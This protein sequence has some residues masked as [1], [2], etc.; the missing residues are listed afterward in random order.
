MNA[1]SPGLDETHDARRRSW[2]EGA[3]G[4]EFPLQN[5]PLGIF[6]PPGGAP[7]AGVAIGG[8]ILDLPALREAGLLDGQAERAAAAAQGGTLNAML[9]LGAAPRRALRRRLFDLLAEGS[10]A[11]SDVEP[12]LHPMAGCTLHLPCAIGDYTDFYAGIHHATNVGLLF[13]PDAPLLPN[14]KHM[15][16]GYHGR[17]SSVR[18]SGTPVRRP[19]GQ[20]SP[21]GAAGPVF[22]PSARL[23]Y[24][25]ELGVW[26]G[27]GTLP[28][29]P[30]PIGRAWDHIAGFCLLND[31][32]ARDVQAWEY[33][34][35]GP[36]LAKNFATTVSCWIVTPEALAPFRIAQPARPSGDPSP[37]PYLH[38]DADQGGG[39]LAVDLEAWL[40]TPGLARA[41]HG[42][43]RLALTSTRHLYW[44]VAQMVAHHSCG[45]CD[46]RPGDLFGSGTISG[47]DTGSLGC[48]LEITSGGRTPLTL[49]DGEQRG[50]LQDGDEVVLRAV[51]RRD[52]FVSVGFGECRAAVTGHA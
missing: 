29:E 28:G 10:A 43:H 34:P 7:R 5:L 52:G 20:T 49:P 40:H 27:Q 30:P 48:L 26:I 9:A 38:D 18:A 1:G 8:S 17:A 42:P 37:L 6:S 47:P 19:C 39:A 12:L 25:L 33:R 45:G 11:R 41:G 16:I 32:S 51:A 3:S 44:T 21:A 22:G 46:L 35:L 31:W 23:D 24:E 13:R 15:P 36:F 4:G 50:F 14:Y 2:V